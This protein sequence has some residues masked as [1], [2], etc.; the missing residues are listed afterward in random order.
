MGSSR[1]MIMMQGVAGRQG[2]DK[3]MGVC[4][5]ELLDSDVDS[6]ADVNS[7]HLL[8]HLKICVNKVEH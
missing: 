7:G 6:T 3:V 5:M 1:M 4:E 8:E 2:G